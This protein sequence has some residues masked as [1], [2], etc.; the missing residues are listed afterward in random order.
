VPGGFTNGASGQTTGGRPPR[1]VRPDSPRL[2][3]LLVG[4]P[5]PFRT[6][7]DRRETRGPGPTGP[8]LE[9]VPAPPWDASGP[10]SRWGISPTPGE[11]VPAPTTVW[12][13][14]HSVASPAPGASK[15]RHEQVDERL[16][17]PSEAN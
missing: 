4:R 8:R 16:S 9:V 2:P 14:P 6:A 11:T 1:W 12:R 17:C 13:N 3:E 5:I 7:P 15:P 10:V